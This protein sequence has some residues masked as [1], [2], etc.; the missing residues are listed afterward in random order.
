MITPISIIETAVPFT[1]SSTIEKSTTFD[2]NQRANLLQQGF[3]MGMISQLE[4]KNA[5]TAVHIWILDNSASMNQADGYRT[6]GSTSVKDMNPLK[7]TRWE[8]IVDT[9]LY[10]AELATLIKA[11]TIFRLLNACPDIASEYAIA[12]MPY[13]SKESLDQDLMRF[14]QW[15]EA[16]HPTGR[17]PLTHQ[18]Y[19]ICQIVQSMDQTIRMNGQHVVLCITTDGLPSDERGVCDDEQCELFRKS[20][21]KL[22][23][24]PIEIIFRLSTDHRVVKKVSLT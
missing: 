4:L 17:T 7:C 24:L 19:E 22:E 6:I 10:H 18:I 2:R 21:R 20:L 9:A 11:P 16:V 12:S 23:R 5:E 13:I 15:L 14:K 8:D 1:R 3:T